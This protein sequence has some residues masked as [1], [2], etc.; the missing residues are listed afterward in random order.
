[1]TSALEAARKRCLDTLAIVYLEGRVLQYS[2]KKLHA[3]RID[4][5]WVESLKEDM[6]A[7]ESLEAFVSR[8]GRMQDTIGDKLIPRALA[9]QAESIGSMLDNLARAE[10]LGWL[11]SVTEWLTAR[12][13]RNRLVHEY[14]TD[15]EILAADTLTALDFVSML[16]ETYNRIRGS[17]VSDPGGDQASLKSL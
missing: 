15:A 12:E 6:D 3:C 16:V 4:A 11:A 8:F 10:R 9:A 2:L 14:V 1:M 5:K 7:A 17:I 13:L